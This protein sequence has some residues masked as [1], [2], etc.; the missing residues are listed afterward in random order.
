LLERKSVI[1]KHCAERSINERSAALFSRRKGK[2]RRRGGRRGKKVKR[3]RRRRKEKK[4]GIF[5]KKFM[6]AQV[7]Q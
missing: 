1:S 5:N 7:P 2:E 3:K 4:K 6:P